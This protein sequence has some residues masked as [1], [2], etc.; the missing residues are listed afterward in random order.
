MASTTALAGQ[1][2]QQGERLAVLAA[3]GVAA[4]VQVDQDRTAR[5]TGAV[6]VQVEQ[7]AAAGVAVGDVGHPLDVA[8]AARQR[9]QQD[10]AKRQPAAQ[11]GGKLG[12]DGAA[13]AGAQGLGHGLLQRRPG[14][15][16]APGDDGEPGRRHGGQPDGRPAAGS[17]DVTLGE[18]QGR[19][20]HQPV[21]AD[22]RHL[23]EEEA[24][25]E[26]QVGYRA[27][28]RQGEQGGERDHADADQIPNGHGCS[29][30][31]QGSSASESGCPA[32]ACRRPQD[33]R[34]PRPGR[35]VV[36]RARDACSS[37]EAML[38]KA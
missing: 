22:D 11:P 29:F 35:P 8:A 34:L 38:A 2:I 19:V 36:P 1:A 20:D 9:Q 37:A 7:V 32:M 16:S 6:T 18:G 17:V 33:Q 15:Q 28:G 3:L 27:L 5:W 4:A 13:P 30:R 12:V 26:A 25:T 23:V 31:A 24:E 10:A 14:P 21:E